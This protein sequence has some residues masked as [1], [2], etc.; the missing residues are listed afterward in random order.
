MAAGRRIQPARAADWRPT[1]YEYVVFFRLLT[2]AT[3]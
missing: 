3:A 1:D 2:K